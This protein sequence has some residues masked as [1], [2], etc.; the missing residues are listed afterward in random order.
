MT[1][2]IV[3]DLMTIR[4]PCVKLHALLIRHCLHHSL[5]NL[6]VVIDMP[7]AL[8]VL[9]FSNPPILLAVPGNPLV[10]TAQRKVH[11]EGPD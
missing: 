1:I 3:N 5:P 7:D 6:S 2:D 9:K 10:K 4:K 11:N 8:P